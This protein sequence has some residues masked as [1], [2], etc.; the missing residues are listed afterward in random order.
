MR[1]HWNA[2]V[3]LWFPQGVEDPD[4]ALLCV[5]VDRSEYWEA[6]GSAYRQF[7]R[8]AETQMSPDELAAGEYAA[9]NR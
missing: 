1:A 6:P 7:R 2:W 5:T 8:K 4:L 9:R 3:E